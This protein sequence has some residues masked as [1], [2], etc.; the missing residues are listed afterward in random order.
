MD[1]FFN[2]LLVVSDQTEFQPL[3]LKWQIICAAQS[4]EKLNSNVCFQKE[5]TW[6]I[7]SEW[8]SSAPFLR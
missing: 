8:F 6:I 3:S 4:T 7:A 2:S 1:I 5:C